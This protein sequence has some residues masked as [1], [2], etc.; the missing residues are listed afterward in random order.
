MAQ[1][2]VSR[3]RNRHQLAVFHSGLLN[4][5]TLCARVNKPSP[6]LHRLPCRSHTN[7]NH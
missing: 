4:T 3:A 7:Y 2:A 5:T 1:F 6:H